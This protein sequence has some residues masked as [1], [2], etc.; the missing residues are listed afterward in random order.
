MKGETVQ[1]TD[2]YDNSYEP[3]FSVSFKKA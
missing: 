1:V 3:Q 2:K